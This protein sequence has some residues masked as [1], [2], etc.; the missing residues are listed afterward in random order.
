M[1]LTKTGPARMAPET[2]AQ[3]TSASNRSSFTVKSPVDLVSGRLLA[4][5]TLWNLIGQATPLLVAVATIP[6]LMRGLGVDRFGV[7][8]VAWMLIGY[9]SLFDFGI[10]QGLTK[11]VADRLGTGEHEDIPPL[12]WTSLIILLFLGVVSGI[13]MAIMAPWIVE[14]V[15]KIPSELQK[16]SVYAFYLVALGMPLVLVTSGVRGVLEAMQRFDVLSA[17]R[18]PMGASTFCAPL[19]V[20]PFSHSLVPI[21]AALLLT[22]FL[23]FIIHLEATLRAMP[24]MRREITLSYEIAR[25]V[26]HFGSWITVTNIVSP[27]M[28]SLD[29]FL[30]GALLSIGAVSYYS[31]PFDMVTKIFLLVGALGSVL[32]PAFAVSHIGDRVHMVLLLHRGLKYVFLAVFPLVLGIVILAPE[33]LRLW[34]GASFADQSTSVLRWLAVGVLV[35]SLSLIVSLLIQAAGRPHVTAI[36]HLIELPFYVGLIWW[37]IRTHGIDGAAWAW[38]TRITLDAI[39][40]GFASAHLFPETR[41][42]LLQAGAVLL[43]AGVL[44]VSSTWIT[45]IMPRAIFLVCALGTFAITAWL[46]FLGPE[47]RALMRIPT[48]AAFRKFPVGNQQQL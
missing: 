6:I 18:I 44:L 24:S 5:N 11:I 3:M 14:K 46:V 35:N 1:A 26:L 32:F 22:R 2:T 41:K 29:R 39:L 42:T 8:S 7:L 12:V 23:G 31:A 37:L 9:F 27:L 48:T 33:G 20:L 45:G 40:L 25:P 36:F 13:F 10:D 21:L 34:L 16:E 30:I 28:T 19:L 38:S 47:E 17:I 4:R 43:A 15:L